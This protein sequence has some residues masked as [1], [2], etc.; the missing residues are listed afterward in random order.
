MTIDN[1]MLLPKQPKF[2]ASKETF[3]SF[4]ILWNPFKSHDPVELFLN[5]I[6]SEHIHTILV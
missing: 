1:K 4:V 5:T 6:L 3:C 2:F